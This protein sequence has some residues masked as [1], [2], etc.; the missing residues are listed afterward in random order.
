M[1]TKMKEAIAKLPPERRKIITTHDAFGYFG[2]AYAMEFI[3]PE[4]VSTESEASAKDVT[5]IIMQIKKEK[6]TAVPRY[7]PQQYRD[8][9]QGAVV[10]QGTTTA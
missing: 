2:A 7:V 4:G 1:E 10:L 8:H 6:T 3:A 5:K 9:V